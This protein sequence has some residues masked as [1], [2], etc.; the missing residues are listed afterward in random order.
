MFITPELINADDMAK[1]LGTVVTH[2]SSPYMAIPLPEYVE[3]CVALEVREFYS[4]EPVKNFPRRL[5]TCG[6]ALKY[7][8]NLIDRRMHALRAGVNTI[9]CFEDRDAPGAAVAVIGVVDVQAFYDRLLAVV[10]SSPASDKTPG[11]EAV[12]AIS[13]LGKNTLSEGMYTTLTRTEAYVR[14]NLQEQ[15]DIEVTSVHTVDFKGSV[16]RQEKEDLRAGAAECPVLREVR[17]VCFG[18]NAE[19]CVDR[20]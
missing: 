2:M 16:C 20:G 17:S 10:A 15:G 8:V 14:E 1:E 9:L 12:E 19:V 18:H 13:S 6:E 11:T 4:H 7:W 5:T 3:M